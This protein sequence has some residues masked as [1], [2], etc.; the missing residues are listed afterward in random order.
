MSPLAGHKKVAL[1]FSGGKD[2]L[3]VVYLLREHLHRLTIYHMD[4][5]DL[6]PETT[7][8]VEHVKAFAPNFVHLKGDVLAAIK[9]DGLPTDL[10]PHSAHPVGQAM[11]EHRHKLV[12]RYDCCV[13]NLMLPI[14]ERIKADGNTLVIRGTKAV[15]MKVLPVA[16]GMTEQ[17]LT[18]Y[19]PLQDWTNQQVF[20]YLAEV[21]APVSRVY[22]HMTNSPECARCSAWWSEGKGSYLKRYHPDVWVDFNE[23]LRTVVDEIEAPLAAL[24]KELTPTLDV[25][26]ALLPHEHD[27]ASET[28]WHA[29]HRVLQGVRLGAT[30]A[31]HVQALQEFMSVPDGS[32]VL[33]IGCGFGKVSTL[34]RAAQPSLMFCNLNSSLVQ[35]CRAPDGPGY[36]KLHDDMHAIPVEAATFDAAM[37]LY[38]LCHGDHHAALTEAA[39]VVRPDGV[40]MVY[41]YARTGGDNTLAEQELCAR[42]F[43]NTSIV[44]LAGNAGWHLSRVQP[45][46]DADDSL[47]RSLFQDDARYDTIFKDLTP[48]LWRFVR[49]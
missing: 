15:D 33:D 9:R 26:R 43:T 44:A 34:M 39:R 7:T 11:G 38:T 5:G 22:R 42:F 37:M 18:T 28:V 6:L 13:R 45:L 29:G 46:L 40:L 27:R 36:S 4:T 17:G 32:Y 24:R 47:F 48:T 14:Y 23:R 19:Y 3:A 20:D 30:D 49:K 21:G 1:C 31:L 16:D 35:L 25:P 8:V 10:L 12:S 2:S 41:D